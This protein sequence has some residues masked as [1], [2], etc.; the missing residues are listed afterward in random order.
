M[1]VCKPF[2]WSQRIVA[3][4]VFIFPLL[5]LTICGP[6]HPILQMVL[7]VALVVH[8]FV[9]LLLADEVLAELC[10]P[11]I[12]RYGVTYYPSTT[13][14]SIREFAALHPGIFKVWDA[15]YCVEKAEEANGANWSTEGFSKRTH[16]LEK[17]LLFRLFSLLVIRV[18]FLGQPALPFLECS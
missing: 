1:R 13:P 14:G 9:W 8:R 18:L 6:M 17:F 15:I 11:L 3:S 5:I 10:A 16:E 4:S 12:D 2:W 7:M